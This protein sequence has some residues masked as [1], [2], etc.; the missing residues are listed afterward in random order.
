MRIAG[1]MFGEGEGQLPGRGARHEAPGIGV[2]RRQ[3]QG[4]GA[5]GGAQD[6]GRQADDPADELAQAEVGQAAA[7]QQLAALPPV[8]GA[9]TS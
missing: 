4:E 1:V 8:E 3:E 7:G 6:A 9:P 5:V 2:G